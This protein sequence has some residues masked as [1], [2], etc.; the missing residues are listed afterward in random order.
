MNDSLY[1][2]LLEHLPALGQKTLEHFI[3]T[4]IAVSG[5]ILIGIP[6][7][8]L[9]ARRIMV[10]KIFFTIAGIIQ[11][12]PSLAMLAFLLPFLGI[13]VI[14]AIVALV[15]Y[16]LLPIA[17]NTYTGITE[18]DASIIEAS[19]GLGFSRN[20]R[21]CLVEL[22][23]ALPTIIAGIRTATVICVGVATLSAFIGA[24][25]L[26]DFINRGLSMNNTRLI[27]LGAI[28]SGIMAISLDITI[29][30]IEHKFSWKNK[31]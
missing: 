4:S 2:F 31:S 25:G 17:R 26:G 23:I 6:F 3:L 12:I 13:G 15:L 5:A 1:L 11:T 16:A 18:I 9:A 28:P 14:P 20:Q 29:G 27:L 21:L 8:I 22:P 7:G 30:A 10:R 24:G 19:D